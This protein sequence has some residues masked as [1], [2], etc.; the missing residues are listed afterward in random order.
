MLTSSR[1]GIISSIG[2]SQLYYPAAERE[3]HTQTVQNDGGNFDSVTL[4][5]ASPQKNSFYHLVGRLSQEVRAATTT[6]DIRTL[7]Q[8]VSSGQYQPDI[9][10][11]A[12]R[13]LFLGEDL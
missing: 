5:A 12:A 1:S 7:R 13:M 6:G 3:V 9:S 2:R 11:I 8:Q 4:S 10:A